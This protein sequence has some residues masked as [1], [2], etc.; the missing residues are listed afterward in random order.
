M[1]DAVYRFLTDPQNKLAVF[2]S[3]AD[4]G[5]QSALVGIAVTPDL[6]IVFDTVKHS[7][8]YPNIVAD[9]RCSL[10]I[11]TTS[12]TTVQYEG[13]A[14]EVTDAGQLAQLKEFYF[15]A[16]PDGPSRESW[17]GIVYIAVKPTWIR[18]SDYGET[19]PRI[20]TLTF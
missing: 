20:E 17:P 19:P 15:A 8:K 7:R 9:P 1:K 3:I 4:T 13:V 11:G 12:G 2:S 5:P 14:R 16:F 6:E 18:F 10:V